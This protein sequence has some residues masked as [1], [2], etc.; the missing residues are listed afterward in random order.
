MSLKALATCIFSILVGSLGVFIALRSS[1]SRRLLRR[2]A[3][4][5]CAERWSPGILGSSPLGKVGGRGATETVWCAGVCGALLRWVR[6]DPEGWGVAV[7]AVRQGTRMRIIPTRG[8]GVCHHTHRS[9]QTVSVLHSRALTHASTRHA[10][11]RVASLAHS[12][13]RHVNE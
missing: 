1:R 10:T 9:T 13:R 2:G 7:A 4:T 11:A 5:D 3:H 6:V 8:K 12:A